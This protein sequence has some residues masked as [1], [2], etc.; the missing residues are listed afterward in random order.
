MGFAQSYLNY[1]PTNA[2]LPEMD[3][4][5]LPAQ[6]AASQDWTGQYTTPVKDQG[7]CGSCWAFSAVEQIESDLIRQHGKSIQLSTQELVDCTGSG[8]RRNGCQGGDPAAA[9]RVIEQL[10]GIETESSYRYTAR[11]GNC[12]FSRSGVAA[13]VSNYQSVG[14]GSESSMQNYVSSTGPLS[15]CVD[16]NSWN[17]Y[18]GGIM[19][20]CGNSVDHCVQVVGYGTSGS[21]SYWKVRN[22][23]GGNWGE[24]GHMRLKI[25][26]NLCQINSEPTAVTVS[27]ADAWEEWKQEHGKVYNGVDEDDYRRSVFEANMLEADEL[28]KANPEADFGATKFSDLTREGFQLSYLNYVPSNVTLPEMDLSDLPLAVASSQDWTGRYT[29]PVKDQ[30]QCGSCWA[31]SA[32]EQIESDLIRQHG[33]SIQL[34]TQELVDCTGSGGRR[35]GC[36]GGDPAA[37]YRVIEQLGGIETESSYRY[38]ARNGNCRFSRSGVAARVSNYQSVGRGSESS[39]QNY[40]GSTGPLSVCVDANS[41]NSYRGGIM[42]SCG[43]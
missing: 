34:S 20:S 41:W 25:G 14:R 30:G 15:V 7:Q 29:T 42:T 12:R 28:Q 4:S 19:T 17:S 22:S 2:S 3:L 10:G 13:R 6:V 40:V 31:F 5:H 39:M 16:A 33:R 8:G 27:V 32:V 21:T 36:Q 38:T 11:N 9:Y 18:R 23:W 26:R 43:N 1:V 24:R 35:N 37:A